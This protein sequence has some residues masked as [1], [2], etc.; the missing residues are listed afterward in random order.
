LRQDFDKETFWATQKD[1]SFIYEKDQSVISRHIN[2][3]FKDKELNKKGNMQKMHIANSDKLVEFYSLDIILA[4]GYRVNSFRAINFR[5]W[6]TKIL[7]QHI[8][9]GF[10]INLNRLKQN[11]K[12]F[13][14]A[15]E[16]IKVL[17]KDNSQVKTDD[18]LE[19][20]KSFSYTW[21]SLDKYDKNSFPKTG[22]KKK[23][24]ITGE[25]LSK[26]LFKLKKELMN[27]GEASNM[28][29]QEKNPGNLEGIIGNIFQAVFGQDVYNTIEEKAAHLLYF[30]IKNH[31]FN[32]GNKRSGAFSFIWFLNKAKF[33]FRDRI[34]PESLATLTI[35][36]A[37]SNPKDKEKMIGIILLLLSFK[38]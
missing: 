5:K 25:E 4:V 8:I 21:F 12:D 9:T 24:S 28:F 18:I 35:L 26:N 22:I 34:N 33:N 29:A 15:V 1:L 27:K 16:D 3:I 30:I 11:N 2:N 31:P 7:K 17:A 37:E 20:I 10:T 19:L 6:A 36:I 13:L 32:D 38:K 14:K 23:I